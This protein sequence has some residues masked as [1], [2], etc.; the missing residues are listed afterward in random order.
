MNTLRLLITFV[1]A[2]ACWAHGAGDEPMTAAAIMARVAANQDRSEKLRSQY[3]YQ[4]RIHVATRKSNGKLLREETADYR[5]VPTPDGTKKE[6][7]AIVGRYSRKGKYFEFKGEPVP[8]ADHLDA[9]L[10]HNFR[11]AFAN[12]KSRDGLAHDL[13]PLT[14]AE[15]ERYTFRLLGEETVEGRPV[16]RIAFRP[17]DKNITWAGEALIDKQEFQPV[18]V[19]TKLS[20]RIPFAVRTLLGTDLPGLGFSVK[21]RRQPDG[22]WFPVSLGTEFHLRVLFFLNR[23][24]S[25]SLQNTAF[26][27]TDVQSAVKYQGEHP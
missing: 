2:G 23:D 18:V 8:D 13:F 1:L 26:E 12:D 5:V 17:R 21:Y 19:F 4:Q 7:Q 14:T 25:L 9:D 22:V 15:Q 10:I 16:Y 11:S 27:H 3:V 6:L 24:I 20:R